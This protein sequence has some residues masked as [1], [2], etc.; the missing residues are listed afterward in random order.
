MQALDS[1]WKQGVAGRGSVGE[2]RGAVWVELAEQCWRGWQR[3]ASDVLWVLSAAQ[4]EVVSTL[5][6]S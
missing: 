5:P 2:A 3:L 1:D 6:K 4:S